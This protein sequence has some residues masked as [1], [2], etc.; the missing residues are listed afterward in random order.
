MGREL[1]VAAPGTRLN[2]EALEDRAT[3][4]AAFALSASS[5]LAFDTATP[6]HTTVTPITGVR[7]NE[8]LVGIDFRT[9]DGLLYALG[10]DA[11]ANT[12]TLYTISV[13]TGRATAVGASG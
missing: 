10:V 9:Q 12:A 1:R 4:A 2:C 7:E 13:Q 11:D 8:S 3:P 5:L 6:A